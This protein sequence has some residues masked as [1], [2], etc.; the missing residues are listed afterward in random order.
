MII[1]MFLF[2]LSFIGLFSQQ[3]VIGLDLSETALRNVIC[4]LPNLQ[5]LRTVNKKSVLSNNRKLKCFIKSVEAT[6][7]HR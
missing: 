7:K 4:N 2:E 5:E 1:N 6:C 3:D